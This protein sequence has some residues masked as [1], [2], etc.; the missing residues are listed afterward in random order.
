MNPLRL[1]L[2]LIHMPPSRRRQWLALNRDR[3]VTRTL[4]ASRLA[5]CGRGTIVQRPLFW[6][7]EFIEL[8]NRVLIWR[9]C[10]IEAIDQY[11]ADRFSPVIRIGDNASL[12]QGCHIVAAGLLEIGS[13]TTISSGVFITDSDH[14]H[15]AIGVNVLQQ[16]LIVR[17][18]KIGRS[19]FLGVGA[20][21]LAG[22]TLGDHCIV[23]ANAVVR[24][25][26][27]DNTILAGVP[28]RPI[29]RFDLATATWRKTDAKGRF[30]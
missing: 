21:V 2:T 3:L 29:K 7:P 26:Y 14:G 17:P 10:R 15:V 19:C 16:P 24:G 5:Q 28:A 30:I 22:T 12:Q 8:G 9:D 4:H 23:A 18:T 25:D 11:H 20:R 13:D 6:T 1:L 27:P